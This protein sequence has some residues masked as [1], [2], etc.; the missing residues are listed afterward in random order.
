MFKEDFKSRLWFESRI[1]GR[2]YLN[3]SVMIF[4]LLV[5]KQFFLTLC[6]C[7]E[8]TH[9][10][11]NICGHNLVFCFQELLVILFLIIVVPPFQ[12]KIRIMTAGPVVTV[13]YP[14]KEPGGTGSVI[15]PTWTVCI[16]MARTHL[17]L[18]VSTGQPGKEIT[19][20][21]RELRWQSDQ[22]TFK[23]FRCLCLFAVHCK[24]ELLKWFD[25]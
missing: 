9:L 8:C 20:P 5:I 16:I 13:L 2:L 15:T 17:T 10:F 11:S 24:W 14:V 6:K 12:P 7:Y 1:L 19:T 21:Q 3:Y 25:D 4:N 23:N 18:M 22:W